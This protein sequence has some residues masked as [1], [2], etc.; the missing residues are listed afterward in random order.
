[1][2][3]FTLSSEDC[4]GEAK[5]LMRYAMMGNIRYAIH[6]PFMTRICP[7]LGC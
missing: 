1:M 4:K 3:H 2:L 6:H 5:L 7:H